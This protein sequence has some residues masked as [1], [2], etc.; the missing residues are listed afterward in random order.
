M[1]A[2]HF[3]SFFAFYKMFEKNCNVC[4]H[5]VNGMMSRKIILSLIILLC[6]DSQILGITSALKQSLQFSE[7][8]K[9]SL[10]ILFAAGINFEMI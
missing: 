7:T 4:F 5:F 10:L 1:F 3:I 8:K 6:I 2:L 9:F